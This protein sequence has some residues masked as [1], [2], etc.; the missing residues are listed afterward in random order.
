MMM[1][2]QLTY[3]HIKDRCRYNKSKF[4]LRHFTSRTRY[5]PI[6]FQTVFSIDS[7]LRTKFQKNWIFFLKTKS[8]ILFHMFS[9]SGMFYSSNL[10][11]KRMV[12]FMNFFW[13]YRMGVY[14][15][16]NSDFRIKRCKSVF[17][18][19]IFINYNS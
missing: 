16:P 5:F 12:Y 8:K 9:Y 4:L 13:S 19:N 3:K 7:L 10:L 11:Q 1:K 6:L 15:L 18:L 17:Y 14:F 2:K